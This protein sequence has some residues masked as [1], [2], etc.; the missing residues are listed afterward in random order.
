MKADGNSFPEFI[1][2]WTTAGMNFVLTLALTCFLSP[3]RGQRGERFLVGGKA[4]RQIQS[5]EFSKRRRTILLL[6]GEKA[7]M[8]EV[9]IQS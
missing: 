5:R 3:R 8:R 7:G 6:L 1:L 4:V 2:G 9:V